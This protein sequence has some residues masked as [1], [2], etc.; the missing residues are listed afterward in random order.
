MFDRISKTNGVFI[1]A[2]I[3]ILSLVAEMIIS[4]FFMPINKEVVVI[5]T[6]LLVNTVTAVVSYFMGASAPDRL[7]VHRDQ[8]PPPPAPVKTIVIPEKP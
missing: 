2:V 1:I 3:C 7:A 8:Q 4:F 5:I 6:N